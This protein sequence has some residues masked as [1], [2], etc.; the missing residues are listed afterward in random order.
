MKLWKFAVIGLILCG[1]TLPLLI[2]KATPSSKAPPPLP[3]PH[4]R[5]S[6]SSSPSSLSTPSNSS[7]SSG[8]GVRQRRV[9]SAESGNFLITEFM[10]MFQSF[11]AGE[12]Q[13]VIGTLLERKARRDAQ[14]SKRTKRAK[15]RSK[16]CSLRDVEVTVSQLG[17]GYVSDE[18][19]VFHYCS[20]KCTANRRNYDLTLAY[21]KRQR[22]L[23]RDQREKARHSPCCRPIAYEKDISFLDNF[24]RYHTIHEF[25][26]QA[27][28]CV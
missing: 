4:R 6:S 5:A 16:P 27:C 1:A 7:S 18:T 17:L 24:S 22:L 8:T 23:T 13:Q 10:E 3:P 21:M 19:V 25:S 11:T 12:L 2:F 14:Q 20:G 26:A 15:K 28:G 9:R